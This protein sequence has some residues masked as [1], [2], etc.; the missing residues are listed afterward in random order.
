VT[1]AALLRELVD[2][3]SV[4]SDARDAVLTG[5]SS[6]SREVA[7]GELFIALPGARRRGVDFL[8]Q[9]FAAGCAAALVPHD[10]TLPPE[11]RSR[12]FQVERIRLNAARAACAIHGRPTE[13]LLTFGVTGTNG[14]TST[15]HILK[16][17]LEAAGH[18]LVMLTTVAHELPGWRRE[19]P[20][21]TP[22]AA[23]LQSVLARALREAATAAVLEVSAHGVALDRI[24]GCRFDGLVF[25]NLSADHQDFFDGIEPYFQHKLRLFIDAAYH[26]PGCV[27][28]IG[29]D[30]TY[31]GRVLRDGRL[32]SLSFGEARPG[33]ARHVSV[34]TLAVTEAGICGH[35]SIQGREYPV[36]T[37]L[38]SSFNRS[39]LAGAAALAVLAGLP[40]A[41]VEQALTSPIVVPGRLTAVASPAPF[42]VVVDFA[43]TD[44]AMQNLLGGLRRECTGRLIVVFGAGGDKDPAR[45]L[46]LPRVV[47]EQ[48]DVGV[49]TLDNPRSEPPGAILETMVRNWHALAGEQR[50]PAELIVEP[51][52][53][54]AIARALE[55][56][57]AGDIVV[58]AGKGHETTQI[59]ADRV[60]HHDDRAI[61]AAWLERRFGATAFEGKAM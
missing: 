42:R 19:T 57:R 2:V 4:G 38:T 11:Y 13:R 40:L 56:A 21:T 46:T 45:R 58:L 50:A 16:H 25:T 18:R 52:R 3:A 1:G 43:H 51:D 59:F 49:I 61:A 15:C 10:E 32:P 41:A 7:P 17:L 37:T 6:D 53:R 55:H 47:I 60:E 36:A 23:L 33:E 12:C 54:A 8:T 24:T 30:D 39:N 35:L 44:S 48:A 26:K 28:A 31:G 20:N 34:E 9:A 27:A 29:T 5:A 14:K 22:D